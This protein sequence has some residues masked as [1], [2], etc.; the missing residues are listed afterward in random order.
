MQVCDINLVNNKF[1]VLVPLPPH[2]RTPN[3]NVPPIP[4]LFEENNIIREDTPLVL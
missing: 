3:F 1:T 4:E 2:T